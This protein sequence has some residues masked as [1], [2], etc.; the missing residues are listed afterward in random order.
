MEI[1]ATAI[2]MRL[3]ITSTLKCCDSWVQCEFS[4]FNMKCHS[5]SDL[6]RNVKS[7]K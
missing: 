1:E 3:M 7:V 5:L 6:M 4:E 2:A